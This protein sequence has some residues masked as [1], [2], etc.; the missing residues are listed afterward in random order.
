MTDKKPEELNETELDQVT[1]GV[2]IGDI[3]PGLTDKAGARFSKELGI[4]KIA[5][6]IDGFT[7]TGGGSDI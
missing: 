5:G 6:K 7:K 3:K 1:G 4:R 2:S